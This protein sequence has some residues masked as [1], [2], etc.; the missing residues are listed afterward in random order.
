MLP[1]LTFLVTGWVGWFAPVPLYPNAKAAICASNLAPVGARLTLFDSQTRRGATC[2]VVGKISTHGTVVNVSE[3]VR[4]ALG[5]RGTIGQVHVYRV[6]GSISACPSYSSPPANT[7][8]MPPAACLAG[9]PSDAL[10]VCL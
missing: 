4:N 8:S 7:C 2:K 3:S 5:F 9:L 1:V 10:V 6:I